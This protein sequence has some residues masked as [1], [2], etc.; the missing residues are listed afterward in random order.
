MI[1]FKN[2]KIE[3]IGSTLARQYDNLSHVLLVKDVPEGYDWAMLVESGGHFDKLL[4]SPMEGGA[5]VTLTKDMLAL[6]GFYSLQLVGTLQADGVTVR[7]TNIIQVY[8]HASLSGDANWPTVPSEFG[9]VESNILEL[10]AHP[11]VPGDNGFWLVWDLDKHAYAESEFPLPE[12]PIGPAG[13][14]GKDGTTYTPAVSDGVL[15]WTNDG[16]L[17]NPEPVDIRGPAGADGKDGRDGVDGK[18]GA[19]GYTPVRGTDYWTAADQ[20][21]IVQDV[22]AALPGGDEVS[23]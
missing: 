5:G 3:H 16:G 12:M 13:A 19:A 10:N 1:L 23:Y 21:A 11:P 2:W 22:L 8:I 20:Q 4:L 15:S 7:H 9:Q 18:D 17:E 14:D 6:E